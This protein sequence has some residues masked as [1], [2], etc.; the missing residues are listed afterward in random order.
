[1]E[2]WPAEHA[3]HANAVTAPVPV[4]NVPPMQFIQELEVKENVPAGHAVHTDAPILFVI[5]PSGHLEQFLE[6]DSTYPG[7]QGTH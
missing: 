7:W 1:M 4:L 5:N 2:K 6:S 3:M